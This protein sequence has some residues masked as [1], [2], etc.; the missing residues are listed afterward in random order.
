MAVIDDVKALLGIED[1]DNKLKV[2][3]TLTE[4]RLK[5]LIGQTEVPSELEYIVTE[6]SIARFNR[7]GS[8]GLSGHTVEGEALTF[9]DNDFDQYA[10]DIQTWRD[11][12]SNQDIGRIRFL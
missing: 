2:I 7:I 3:I 4:N 10:D 12:Q 1:E 6:V 11:A 5:T 9:K 8:E